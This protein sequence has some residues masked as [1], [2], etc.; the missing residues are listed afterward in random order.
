MNNNAFSPIGATLTET[1]VVGS[2]SAAAIPGSGGVVVMVY[3]SGSAVAFIKLGGA[4]MAAADG[5]DIPLPPNSMMPYS[6]NPSSMTHVRIFS[7][8]AGMAVY[9]M[10]GGGV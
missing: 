3:N 10:R 1:T 2:T 4:G 6:I 7:G 8:T 5:T 9:V